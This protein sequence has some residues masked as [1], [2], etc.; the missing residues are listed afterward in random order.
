MFDAINN[1]SSTAEVYQFQTRRYFLRYGL[2]VYR[3]NYKKMAIIYTV[4]GDLAIIR[5]IVA[6]A[7]ITN[8]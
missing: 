4:H 6:G 7:M 3:I 1:L 2:F 5:R 8:V